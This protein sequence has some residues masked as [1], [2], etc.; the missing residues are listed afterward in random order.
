MSWAIWITGPPGSGK[1]AIARA[2]E[3]ELRALGQPVKRLELD[4][5][6][7]S[8][9]PAPRYS[10]SERDVVYRALG[11]LAELLVESGTPVLIDATAHRRVWRDLVRQAV[12][13]FAEVQLVCPLEVCR[14]RERTRLPGHAPRD[15]YAQAGQPGATVPGVD[16]AY[17][18]AL[19]PELLID[20]SVEPVAS[21]VDRIMGL[22]RDLAR[23][24]DRPAEP[25][26]G[27]EPGWAIWITG[28]PG[29]GKSTLASRVAESLHARGARVR[30]LGLAPVQERLL[31]DRPAGEHE[32]DIV[33]RVL[34]YG[35]KLLTEAG[36][37]V[38]VDATA[39]RR[40][41]REAARASIPSFAEIQLLC[42]TETCLE[43][44][45]AV[46]WGLTFEAPPPRPASTPDIVLDYEESPRADLSIRTDVYDVQAA[47]ER[48][49]VVIQ[50]L[51]GSGVRA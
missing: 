11:Y 36:V 23:A 3:T 32:Q 40:V 9:T 20:T 18:P 10:D 50:R 6:R 30:L 12:P 13:R 42:P 14:Q 29:S 7:K 37:A 41:W 44:E 28:R 17:E 33:H 2:V 1:S 21:S 22:A 34:A 45:R 35:A 24:A 38:I 46:R 48:V 43:R 19:A 27:G 31:G 47:T 49:L 39:G 16:V 4:E 25:E 26:A 8:I 5:I 15:I 51:A